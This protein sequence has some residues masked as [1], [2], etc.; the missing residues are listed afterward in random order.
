MDDTEFSAMEE[1]RKESGYPREVFLRKVIT[2]GTVRAAPPAD[3]PKL[4]RALGQV[5]NNLNQLTATANS[6]HFIDPKE[7]NAVTKDLKHIMQRIH[8]SFLITEN[9]S[10]TAQIADKDKTVDEFQERL[11]T[12]LQTVREACESVSSIVKI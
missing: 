12:A 1:K 10:L 7:L 9:D 6:I 5:G 3:Y 4:I 2:D 8:Q 11:R